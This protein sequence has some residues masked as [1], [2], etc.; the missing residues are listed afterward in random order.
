MWKMAFEISD[1]WIQASS[2]YVGPSVHENQVEMEKYKIILNGL[3]TN[4]ENSMHIIAI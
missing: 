3:K 4:Y 2:S 1:N